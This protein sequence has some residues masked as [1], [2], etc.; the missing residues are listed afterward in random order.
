MS[1]EITPTEEV[2]AKIAHIFSEYLLV[3][4]PV[5][6]YLTNRGIKRDLIEQEKVGFCPPFLQY[7]F[8]LM[9]GRIVVPISNVYGNI[10]AFA[11]RQY[12]PSAEAAKE[13]I[14]TLYKDDIVSADK[15]VSMWERGKWINEPYP[16][17]KH[18]YNLN[19][20]KQFIRET[21]YVILVEGYFDA[22]VMD[23]KGFKNT[24]AVCSTSLSERHAVLLKRYCDKAILLLDG[25]SAGV[26]A[27]ERM[28]PI[29]NEAELSYHSIYLP[30]GYDPDDFIRKVGAKQFQKAID[31]IINNNKK[32]LRIKLK[33]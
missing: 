15:K 25:D 2:G 28:H 18:L 6:D 22:L 11:G 24:V 10:L 14:R 5:I 4:Q 21:G 7:W 33:E 1:K 3:N 17:I 30:N 32:E 29:L 23:S 12:D 13:S 26:K 20:A 9:K 8:P 31:S 19:N 27:M 16:K